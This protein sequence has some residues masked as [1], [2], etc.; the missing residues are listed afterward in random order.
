MAESDAIDGCILPARIP[1][2]F[3][4]HNF[5]LVQNSC[6]LRETA[7]VESG[8]SGCRIACAREN[9]VVLFEAFKTAYRRTFICYA[10]RCR[11]SA[12]CVKSFQLLPVFLAV[13]ALP[14]RRESHTFNPAFSNGSIMDI[15]FY[16][17]GRR[18]HYSVNRKACRQPPVC[19]KRCGCPRRG[20][21]G[22]R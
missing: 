17:L 3:P 12:N 22:L 20:G 5:S 16:C 8:G 19:W 1:C 14:G 10:R 18:W 6:D 21:D 11:K 2:T 7:G 13:S 15:G 4:R 9:Q